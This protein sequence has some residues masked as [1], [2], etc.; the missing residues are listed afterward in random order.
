MI[1]LVVM[2]TLVA[3]VSGVMA[4][5]K[6]APAPAPAKPAASTAPTPAPTPPEKVKLES[7]SGVIQKVDEMAKTIDVKGKVKKEDKTLTFAIDDK[8]KITKGKATLTLAEFKEG[9][10]VSTQYK[11]DGDKMVAVAIKVSV[12]KTAPKKE[13]PKKEEPKK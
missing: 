7:F 3:F 5:Q 1:L 10:H 4:Q 2:L 11:K 8:T 6:A 12:P 13:E 9:M